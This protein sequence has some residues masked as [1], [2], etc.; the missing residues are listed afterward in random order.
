M[1]L[2]TPFAPLFV[3]CVSLFAQDS[4]QKSLA[5]L[6]KEAQARKTAHAK[7]VISNDNL[8][9]ADKGPLPPLELDGPDNTDEIVQAIKA[10]C[11]EQKPKECETLV[12]D[13]YSRYFDMFTSARETSSSLSARLQDR[14]ENGVD[15]NPNRDP[16]QNRDLQRAE[17]KTLRNDQNTLKRYR[18]IMGRIQQAMMKVRSYAGQSGKNWAWFKIPDPNG[19]TF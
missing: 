17:I 11:Q 4:P 10:Y 2:P 7:T 8:T 3:F 14:S 13:W 19:N 15:F 1:R 9:A 6:A 16:K 5:D 18:F 12:H